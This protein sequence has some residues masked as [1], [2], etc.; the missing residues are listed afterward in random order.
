AAAVL[1]VA[2]RDNGSDTPTTQ[3]M[4]AAATPTPQAV[5][6]G[7]EWTLGSA[8][9]TDQTL[10]SDLQSAFHATLAEL[11]VPSGNAAPLN[12]APSGTSAFAIDFVVDGALRASF[13]SEAQVTRPYLPAS[14]RTETI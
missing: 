3:S 5:F 4:L 10:S 7:K 6:T 13:G 9:I 8:A 12:I 2:G 1:F 14:Q 11:R